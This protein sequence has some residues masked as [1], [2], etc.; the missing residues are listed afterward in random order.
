MNL[1]QPPP[2]Q[3]QQQAQPGQSQGMTPTDIAAAVAL[4]LKQTMLQQQPQQQQQRQMSQAEI[5]QL[6]GTYNPDQALHDALFGPNATPETRM[7]GLQHLVQ[8]IV[9]NAAGMAQEISYQHLQKFNEHISD[10]LEDA[11]YVANARFFDE[12]YDG[13]PALKQFDPL[14][15]GQLSQYEQA[16]D[17]PKDRAARAAYVRDKF[18][19][20]V[21]Q[22]QPDFDPT[23]PPQQAPAPGRPYANSPQGG[24][25]QSGQQG[26]Q[27]QQRQQGSGLPSFGGGGSG[28]TVGATPM[29]TSGFAPK[30]AG[31]YGF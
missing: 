21:K 7:Q 4:A 6:L 1:Q 23:R 9:A 20:I 19:P 24:Q 12:I 10:P 2:Q 18:I 26:Q 27:Q 11:R 5:D 17:Y 28:A 16:Q 15:K 22:I 8:G 13:H 3:Q 25:Q 29:P 31:Q 30:G 14:L